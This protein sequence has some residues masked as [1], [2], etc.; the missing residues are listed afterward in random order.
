[1]DNQKQIIEKDFCHKRIVIC[2]YCKG[3]KKININGQAHKCQYCN[4]EGLLERV[5]EGTLRLFQITKNR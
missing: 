2:G 3:T 1:M 5:S 4:G